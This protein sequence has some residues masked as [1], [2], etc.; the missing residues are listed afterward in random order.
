M[1][2]PNVNPAHRLGVFCDYFIDYD[3]EAEFTEVA[4]ALRGLLASSSTYTDDVAYTWQVIAAAIDDEKERAAWVEWKEKDRGRIVDV[5]YYLKARD[6][7]GR[8]RRWEIETYNP[9]FGCTVGFLGW[10]GDAA[11][12]VYR[13]KHDSYV[14][15]LDKNNDARRVEI[16]DEWLVSGDIVLYRSEQPDRVERLTLPSLDSAGSI[17]ADEAERQNLLPPGYH[18][19]NERN[20]ASRR[21]R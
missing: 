13:D 7:L 8:P 6:E 10:A 17:G 18:E 3:Y 19:A 4:A 1:Y 16:S 20:K 12:L 5:F 15:C 2:D 11:V 14:A 9:Y 21:K